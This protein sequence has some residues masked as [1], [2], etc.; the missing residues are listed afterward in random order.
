MADYNKP[1]PSP[2]PYVTQPF[3]DGAK[4]GKLMLPRCTSC[5]RVHWYPRILCPHCHSSSIEWF[6]AGERRTSTVSGVNP[7]AFRRQWVVL[8][9]G[10][11]G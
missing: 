3:W 9:L 1:I 4:E 11:E 5:N 6:E 7:L 8:E 10:V 2:D